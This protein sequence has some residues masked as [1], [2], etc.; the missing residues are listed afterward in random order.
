MYNLLFK[1][2]I[3]ALQFIN[4]RNKSK[5]SKKILKFVNTMLLNSF[6]SDQSKIF[7]IISS[8]EF[9]SVFHILKEILNSIS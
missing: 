5:I 6:L 7:T 3:N 9:V 8:L 4:C 2:I 1:T